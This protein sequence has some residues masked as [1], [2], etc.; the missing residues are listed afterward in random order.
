MD[1]VASSTLFSLKG[2]IKAVI[3]TDVFQC[4][5]MFTGVFA[6]IIKVSVSKSESIS[7]I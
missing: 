1:L 2:G 3:W 5:I 7:M 4:L 6:V